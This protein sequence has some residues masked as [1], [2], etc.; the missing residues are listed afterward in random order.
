[1]Y[2]YRVA[3][4]RCVDSRLDGAMRATCCTDSQLRG[5]SSSCNESECSR[6][7]ERHDE[8]RALIQHAVSPCAVWA[9][10]GCNRHATQAGVLSIKELVCSPRLGQ[11]DCVK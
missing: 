3:V 9:R 10:F 5:L 4:G 8:M 2:Q 1:M 6:R 7:Q 11:P